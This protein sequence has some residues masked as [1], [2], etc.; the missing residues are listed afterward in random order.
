MFTALCRGER[1]K[2]LQRRIA[3]LAEASPPS[4]TPS[5]HAHPHGT[6]RTHQYLDRGAW[7]MSL[8]SLDRK[9]VVSGKSVSVRVDLGGRRLIKTKKQHVQPYITTK[10]K[11][12]I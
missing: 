1:D 6:T 2:A 10:Y 11:I 9:S 3:W 8:P 4:D 7:T 12:Y 5:G